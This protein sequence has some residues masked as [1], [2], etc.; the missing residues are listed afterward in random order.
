MTELVEY[1]PRE[2]FGLGLH[3]EATAV[4][5]EDRIRGVVIAEA[6]DGWLVLGHIEDDRRLLRLRP[7]EL[8]GLR[9]ALVSGEF[10]H[11]M[12]DHH[13]HLRRP[14]MGPEVAAMWKYLRR[15]WYRR[16]LRTVTGR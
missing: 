9:D 1:Y 3:W 11:L 10:D 16:L 5:D 4:D 8:A 2:A 12:R 6:Q 7:A 14:T 13:K 15:P